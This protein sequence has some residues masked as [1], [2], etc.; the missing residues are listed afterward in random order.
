[1]RKKLTGF[2]AVFACLL[3]LTACSS[4]ASDNQSQE[5]PAETQSL[6]YS[7]TEATAQ[8]MDAIVE[9]GRMEEQADYAVIYSG[10]QSWETAKEEIGTVD[11]ST[12]ADGNGSAD[13]F[14]DKSIVIDDEGNYVVTVTVTGAQKTADFIASY[15]KDLSDYAHIVTNVNYLFIRRVDAAGRTEHASG[16]GNYLLYPDPAQPDH[17]R[18]R[19]TLC[20]SGQEESRERC[21]R[22][23]S[24]GCFPECTRS[25]SR[26]RRC[27]V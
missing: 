8:Q 11:F 16:Y 27:T 15:N 4:T 17:C 9:A 22:E 12:D 2:F 19:K 10:L 25:C 6:L 5:I 1:M 7:N 21:G 18:L 20:F 26:S 14:T 23:K 3:I 24:R 13:C